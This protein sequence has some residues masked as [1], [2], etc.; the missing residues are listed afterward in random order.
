MNGKTIPPIPQGSSHSL[1]ESM[2]Q[3]DCF[4][5]WSNLSETE[6]LEFPVGEITGERFSTLL[7]SVYTLS[8]NLFVAK[9]NGAYIV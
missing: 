8:A 1:L 2:R 3:Q 6:W 4:Y 5:S 9:G 7:L